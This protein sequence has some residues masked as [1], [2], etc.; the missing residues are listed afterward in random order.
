MGTLGLQ[1]VTMGLLMSR[2]SSLEPAAAP[3]DTD[4]VTGASLTP[5]TSPPSPASGGRT[6]PMLR[7]SLPVWLGQLLPAYPTTQLEEPSSGAEASEEP[8][9]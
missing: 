1:R 8:P 7:H 6:H 5:R 4:V 2:L 3:G 9:V